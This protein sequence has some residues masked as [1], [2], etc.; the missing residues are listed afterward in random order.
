MM[1]PYIAVHKQVPVLVCIIES[2]TCQV[3]TQLI[4]LTRSIIDINVINSVVS[5]LCMKAAPHYLKML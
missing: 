4:N 1:A 5:P 2:Q 3:G